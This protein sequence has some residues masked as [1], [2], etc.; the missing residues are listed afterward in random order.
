M[1]T[2]YLNQGISVTGLPDVLDA[3]IPISCELVG[4]QLS[5]VHAM[6]DNVRNPGPVSMSQH[7]LGHLTCS[8]MPFSVDLL[9]ASEM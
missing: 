8:R 7:A 9:G 2:K 5:I 1:K 3:L 4:D 6:S